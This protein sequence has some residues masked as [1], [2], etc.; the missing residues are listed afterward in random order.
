DE[1]AVEKELA[2]L[3]EDRQYRLSVGAEGRQW[4]E[5]YHSSRVVIS[6]MK[7]VYAEVAEKHGWGREFSAS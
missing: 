4:F 1:A 7:D 3:A 5:K 6:R 2:R